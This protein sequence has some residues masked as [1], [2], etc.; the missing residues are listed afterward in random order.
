M[1]RKTKIIGIIFGS[2][3]LVY[4][5]GYAGFYVFQD[6]FIFQS[7]QLSKDHV[8]VF[9]QKFEELMIPTEDGEKVS[10][11]LFRADSSKGL[12]LYFHGNAGS[13][14]RWGKFATDFT[15]LGYDVLMMDYRGYGKST[16]KPNEEN[17]YQDAQTVLKWSEENLTYKKLVIYGRS[18]GSAVASNL[19]TT[20]QADLLI[21]ETPFE[22]L[23]DVL[24]FFSSH[25]KFSNKTFL[26]KVNCKR[27][28]IQGTHDGVVPLAS[29]VK[30][31][32]F[33]NETD[34][35]VIIEGG[36]HNNLSEF[37]KYHK[38]LKEVLN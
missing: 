2:V 21:L 14:Q 18:L 1:H 5:I 12:I 32:P 29:A 7:E 24:Y 33:L 26:P 16:G 25:Y 38:T 36:N 27:V 4:L 30:L 9:D 10:A 11:L 3:L 31:K 8:F 28:I 15:S 6:H 20:A 19:A 17:L 13:L 37:G 23:N 35:F 22:E 34:R